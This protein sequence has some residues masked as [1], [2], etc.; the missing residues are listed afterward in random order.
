MFSLTLLPFAVATTEDAPSLARLALA[1]PSGRY[2]GDKDVLGKHIHAVMIYDD[3]AGTMHFE[4]SGVLA[5]NCPNEAFT[6]SNGLVSLTNIENSND[7]ITL[8]LSNNDCKLE[9][10]EYYPDNDE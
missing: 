6:Y 7:C 1:E 2:V 5:V 10:I 3:A 8:A 4:L 9:E